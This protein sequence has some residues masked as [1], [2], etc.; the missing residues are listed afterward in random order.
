MF[1]RKNPLYHDLKQRICF[2]DN[3]LEIFSKRG[4]ITHEY[5]EFRGLLE[6]RK[7][8]YLILGRNTALAIDKKVCDDELYQFIRSV[9]VHPFSRLKRF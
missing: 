7:G 9:A 2:Y 8:L 5:T 3:Y 1:Y 4:K 6:D